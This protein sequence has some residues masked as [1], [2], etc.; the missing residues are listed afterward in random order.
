MFTQLSVLLKECASVSLILTMNKDGTLS[1]TVLP[2]PKATGEE[3]AAL[4]TPL[5]LTATPSELDEGF[6]QILME[7]VGKHESL[8]EQ[9]SNTTAIL[10]AA[11]TE[12]QKKATTALSKPSKS[13]PTKPSVSADE[14]GGEELDEDA[15]VEGNHTEIAATAETTVTSTE[16]AADTSDSLWK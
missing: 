4:A 1:V 9:L 7:Y 14:D 6:V 3:A 11:K 12:S 5:T 15:V 16:T 2:K 8:A 13:T 10:D